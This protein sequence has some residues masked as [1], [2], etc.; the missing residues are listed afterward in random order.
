LAGNGLPIAFCFDQVEALQMI[1]KDPE[2]LFVYGQ[3]ISTLHDNTT[4]TFLISCVQSSFKNELD[5]ARRGADYDRITSSGAASLDP[6][7]RAQAEQ[8]IAARRAAAGDAA[9][10]EG[11]WPLERSE[12]EGLFSKG[13][14]SP[15]QLLRVCAE[16]YETR[17][18]GPATESPV[19]AQPTT[20]A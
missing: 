4:N 12:F 14:I 2:A 7:N 6:L 10:V 17:V 18:R 13:A 16:R 3:L 11:C 15:R 19:S 20:A 1:P 9:A 5:D 8:L